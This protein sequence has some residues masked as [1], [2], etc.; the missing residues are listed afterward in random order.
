MANSFRLGLGEDGIA[1]LLEV[2]PEE[3]D[4]ELEQACIAEEEARGKDTEEEKE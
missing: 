2:A 4:N 1:D 3:L